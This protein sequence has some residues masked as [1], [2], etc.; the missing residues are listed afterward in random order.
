MLF[1]KYIQ[2]TYFLKLVTFFQDLLQ[3]RNI[4]SASKEDLLQYLR[5]LTVKII[6]DIL[7][8]IFL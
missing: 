7:K 1:F 3:S 8:E 6:L 5:L 2:H 4:R